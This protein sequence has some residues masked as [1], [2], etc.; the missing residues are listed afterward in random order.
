MPRIKTKRYLFNT[1]S[2]HICSNCFRVT[3]YLILSPMAGHESLKWSREFCN[4][5][6]PPFIGDT[7]CSLPSQMRLKLVCLFVTEEM[8]YGIT[9]VSDQ[10]S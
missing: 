2:S 4:V 3:Y 8:P 10:R 5:T 6:I 9:V 7:H 1:Q